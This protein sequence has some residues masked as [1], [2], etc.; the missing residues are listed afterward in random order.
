MTGLFHDECGSL[1]KHETLESHDGLELQVG[2]CANCDEYTGTVETDEEWTVTENQKQRSVAEVSDEDFQ[3]NTT[4]YL[5]S[6]CDHNEAY[7]FE[8]SAG[9]GDEDNLIVYKCTVCGNTERDTQTT[10]G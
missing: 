6:D 8:L 10:W 4:E 5:F 1:L 3:A 2:Y 7:T 9:R